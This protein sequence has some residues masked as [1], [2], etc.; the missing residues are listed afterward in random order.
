MHSRVHTQ[1]TMND[2]FSFLTCS[3]ERDFPV[4]F[5]S[6][7]LPNR[8]LFHEHTYIACRH[9]PLQKLERY[10]RHITFRKRL[11]VF[12]GHEWL[13]RMFSFERVNNF[14]VRYSRVQH[15][16]EF[17]ER[18][19]SA[20]GITAKFNWELGEINGHSRA[21]VRGVCVKRYSLVTCMRV[22]I[23]G[24]HKRMYFQDIT[25]FQTAQFRRIAW[26]LLRLPW[27]AQ[28]RIKCFRRL[29]QRCL[30]ITCNFAACM[31]TWEP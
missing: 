14:R 20:F 24:V 17:Q 26:T 10:I 27:F 11:R 3:H 15:R 16:K 28:K 2:D 5:H 23:D 25:L 9:E 6:N 30:E 7:I 19:V 21:C 8:R 13:G 12:R 4:T 31:T 1:E 18:Y 22:V 29:V